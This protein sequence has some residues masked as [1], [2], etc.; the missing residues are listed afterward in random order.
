MGGEPRSLRRQL[1]AAERDPRASRGVRTFPGRRGDAPPRRRRCGPRQRYAA[2][3]R[4]RLAL[5]DLTSRVIVH[6]PL[7]AR[8]GR[9][10]LRAADVFVLAASR[11]SYGTVWGEAMAFG[12]PVVGWHAGNLPHLAE[13][14]REGLLVEPGDFGRSLE[15]TASERPRGRHEGAARGGGEAPRPLTPNMGCLVGALLRSNQ[16][17]GQTRS[18]QMMRG[19]DRVGARYL[20]EDARS[21]AF[22]M[23][24]E[25]HSPTRSRSRAVC[26]RPL[27]GPGPRRSPR[28]PP[29]SRAR[30][31]RR[32][33]RSARDPG[34]ARSR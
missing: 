19:I 12:L 32:R 21:S 28:P 6:G 15:G 16:G 34:A 29:R 14:R 22:S 27:F 24:S 13:D 10:S 7:R 30:P 4:S 17:S 1:A 26:E 23:P 8:G 31:G 20:E 9:D 33:L 11:E 5:T 3:V 18:D 2:R 25:R